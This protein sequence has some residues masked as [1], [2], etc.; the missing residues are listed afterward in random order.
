[1]T[2]TEQQIQNYRQKGYHLF[3]RLLSD[4]ETDLL[5][6]IYLD[7]LELTNRDPSQSVSDIRPEKTD[8]NIY[9]LRCAHLMHEAFDAVVRNKH[10]L[11]IVEDLIGPNIR[12]ILCQ[13]LYKPPHTG[14]AIKWHQD[15]QYFQVNKPD[16]VVSCWLTLDDAT[17]DNGCM[18]VSPGAHTKPLP[19]DTISTGLHIPNID[20]SN[21]LPLE[22][23]RG[24]CMLHHGLMPHRTLA[25][26]TSSHRRALAIHYMD[27][28]AQLPEGRRN[29]PPQNIPIIRGD[30]TSL[31]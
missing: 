15:N 29:E 19:H 25:N 30:A 17:V 24:H 7:C 27:A 11:D 14:D 8:A 4:E 21:I 6:K 18:W 9:Q 26:K 28:T 20:E 3:G 1:M 23:K 31:A 5:A 12:L 16:G 10:L 2:L 22:M 13:G